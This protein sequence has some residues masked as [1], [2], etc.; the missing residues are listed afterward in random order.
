MKK[1]KQYVFL[2][3]KMQSETDWKKVGHYYPLTVLL[4]DMNFC[5]HALCTV[6]SET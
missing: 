2:L 1:Y 5:V 6:L 4:A 3:C